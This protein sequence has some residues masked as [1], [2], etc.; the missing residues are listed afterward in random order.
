MRKQIANK[1]MLPL[2]VLSLLVGCRME[3]TNLLT[4]TSIHDSIVRYQT[5]T[6]D[7][8]QM[9][10][11][12]YKITK[13][14]DE[15]EEIRQKVLDNEYSTDDHLD[16]QGYWDSV[17]KDS[18]SKRPA[19]NYQVCYEYRGEELGVKAVYFFAINDKVVSF[20]FDNNVTDEK[21]AKKDKYL[22]QIID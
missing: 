22:R 4:V 8:R 17:K 20:M 1:V 15:V 16:D 11:K 21:A 5:T 18:D 2:V 13:G 7:L 10:G 12:P 14:E 6:D 9:Y 19:G 3:K